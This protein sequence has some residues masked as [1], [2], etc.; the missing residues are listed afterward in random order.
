L[1]GG[2]GDKVCEVYEKPQQTN[3]FNKLFKSQ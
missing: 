2:G 3:F 1:K